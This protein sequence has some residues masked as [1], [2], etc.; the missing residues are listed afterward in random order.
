MLRQLWLNQLAIFVIALSCMST[1]HA[2]ASMR[3]RSST[4]TPITFSAQKSFGDSTK[5]TVE[6][7]GD[8]KIIYDQQFMS[9]DR[10]VID[11]KAETITAEGNLVISSP[12]AY[13]EG[14][15]AVMS[16]R[17]NTGTIINGFV[18]SG[19]VIFE[20]RVVKKTGPQSFDAEKASFTACTTCPTAWTFSGSRIQAELGGYAY[21]KSAQLRVANF[22]TLWLPYLIVPLKSERQ[23]GLLIPT[24]DYNNEGGTAIGE[25]FFWAATRSQDLTFTP[26][27]YTLRSWKAL[28]DYRY[29]ISPTA[30]GELSAG[31]INDKVFSGK[32][33]WFGGA[34]PG[35]RAT[36]TFVKYGHD[37]DLPDGFNTKL[38]IN[39]VSDL[40]Y[41]R[42]F[43]E[44][45]QG[46]GDPA[47]ENRMTLTRN[48]ERT[49]SSLDAAYYINQLHD[50]VLD[51]N[52]ESVHR[53]P[54]IRF[55]L[56]DRPIASTGLL[57]GLL[58][59]FHSDYANFTRDDL[60]WD[61]A[62]YVTDS[63]GKAQ[64]QI[65]RARNQTVNNSPLS[66]GGPGGISSGQVFD[67]TTDLVRTGQR[68]DL[69]PELSVP[70]R[71]GSSIDVLPAVSFRH[72]QYSLNVT[73]PQGTEFDSSPY[74]QYLRG[75]LSF[76]TRFSKTFG[77]STPSE[78]PH[79]AVTNWSDN[80]SRVAGSNVA[81]TPIAPVHPDVYRHEIEP[82]ILLDGVKDTHDTGQSYF[83]G[84]SAHTPSFLD[85][86]PISDSDVKSSRGVQFDYEDRLTNRNTI[87]TYLSNRLVKKSWNADGT[88]VYKQIASLKLGESYD[89]DENDEKNRQRFVL[90]DFSS[91]LDVRLDH[92]E[93]NTLVRYF[94][95]HGKTNTSSRA[96]I[97]DDK[98]RYLEMNFVENYLITI[99]R[100]DA[101]ANHTQTIGFLAGFTEKYLTFA[102]TVDFTP[103]NWENFQFAVKSWGA[104]MNFKPPGN[105]WGILLTLRQD[106]GRPLDHHLSFDYNFGGQGPKIASAQ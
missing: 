25:S 89:I 51:S 17:D 91:L 1:A 53:I 69:Q 29:V 41:P 45:I 62:N 97:M 96:K 101:L 99:N 24:I 5:Q 77:E 64:R 18:K 75:S 6:L 88:T 50:N 93:T 12:Q 98:G 72:T 32:K 42:D 36:R 73:A 76:R 14:D 35:N 54:E 94:P 26:K 57:S 80:E 79:P 16:Y 105:C 86:Q 4:G 48:T 66:D 37:Y 13:L 87:S 68:I 40:L 85:S 70:F 19:P 39:Y 63:T 59:R 9:C 106:I 61:D 34:D 30:A 56:V 11:R 15:S 67:P 46:L 23:T 8:V 43:P 81:L 82:E 58:F 95:Y 28:A 84:P 27:F 55:D 71:I 49:H 90:S 10:A 100:D 83:L 31:I 52:R 7:T 20:G 60:A 104:F 103:N 44:E 92:F 47:L 102:G 74:R 21:I 2:A 33:D 78:A 38:K 3:L 65:D 22:P